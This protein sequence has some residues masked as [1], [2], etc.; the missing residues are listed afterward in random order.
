MGVFRRVGRGVKSVLG[1]GGVEGRCVGVWEGWGEVCEH[2]EV[3]WGVR[4]GKRRCEERCGGRVWGGGVGKC[5]N[6]VGVWWGEGRCG[7]SCEGM[8]KCGV[9]CVKVC[10]GEGGDIYFIEFVLHVFELVF[11]FL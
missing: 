9:R 1:C 10:W 8:G 3:C 2:G 5:G 11:V 4:K 6:C 7:E